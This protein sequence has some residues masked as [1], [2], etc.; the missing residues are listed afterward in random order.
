[1]YCLGKLI[2][3]NPDFLNSRELG[4]LF[5]ARFRYVEE[6]TSAG[7]DTVWRGIKGPVVH[8]M[9][10]GLAATQFATAF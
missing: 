10:R 9:I 5:G 7:D 2:W 8:V 3:L 6:T 4:P 1:V